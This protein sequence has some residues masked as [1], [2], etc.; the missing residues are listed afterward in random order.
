M[1]LDADDALQLQ[2]DLHRRWHGAAGGRLRMAY[3]ARTI[4]NC[5]DAAIAGG[6]ERARRG[7]AIMQMHVAEL[8]AENEH[9]RATR[10]TSTVPAPQALAMATRQAAR[11]LCRSDEIGTLEPGKRADL[12]I[13][14]P[15]TAN[16]S[17]RSPPRS[18][19]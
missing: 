14:D 16:M 11:A 18:R 3:T 17:T 12:V 7:N 4:F 19:R 9:S 8:P 1:V 2:D 13:V 15:A 5:S 10:G 6:A